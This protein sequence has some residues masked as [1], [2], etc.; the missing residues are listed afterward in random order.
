MTLDFVNFKKYLSKNNINLFDS[1][2]RIA[3]Y[4]Y[5]NLGKMLK[6]QIGGN[7]KNFNLI[8]QLNNVLLNHFIDSLLNKNIERINHII[9][10]I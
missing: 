10:N 5:N 8:K 3:Y 9:N 4:R 2:Y 6:L 7:I 1:Q